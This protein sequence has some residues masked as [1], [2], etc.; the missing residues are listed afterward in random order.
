[1]NIK[2]IGTGTMGST[3]RANTSVLVDNILFDCG[4]GTVKQLERYNK[5]TK[6]IKCLV[7]THFHADH[8]FDI[9]NLLIGKRIRNECNDKLYIILPITGRKK[10]I[11][12]MKFSFADGDETAYDDIEKK[13]NVE[14]IELDNNETYNFE[15][16]KIT[17]IE[18]RHG[19][20]VPVC[21]YL[22]N[23]DNI[24]IGYT[25]DTG[26]CDNFFEMCKQANY[27]FVDTTTLVSVMQDVHISFEELKEFADK[28]NNCK[29]YAIHRGDYEIQDKGK[30]FVPDDG[31]VIKI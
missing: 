22:L 6:D 28:Y 23:K 20:C 25:G 9:P 1:M 29:F 14:F 5:Q 31:E 15:D 11:D 18:S 3:T 30:V 17:L 24:T 7:I 13:Y 12:M 10:V 8:F 16:Y 26:I 27:M 21:G 2:F 4:M 19:G